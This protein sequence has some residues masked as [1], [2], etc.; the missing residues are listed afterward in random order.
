VGDGEV[1]VGFAMPVA[2]VFVFEGGLGA[3]PC[4]GRA[5][6]LVEGVG[7]GASV[8]GRVFIALPALAVTIG[9]IF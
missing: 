5:D 9:V 1:G 6:A 3:G 7:L 4:D 8:R 2:A